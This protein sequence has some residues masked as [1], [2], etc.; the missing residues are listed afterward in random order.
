MSAF[1]PATDR[2]ARCARREKP[3][4]A[5]E[6]LRG[7]PGTEG[8]CAWKSYPLDPIHF[9]GG[10]KLTFRCANLAGHAV[11][12]VCVRNH[13]CGEFAGSADF[14]FR[15]EPAAIADFEGQMSAGDATVGFVVRLPMV[16]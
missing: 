13:G 6:G 3:S 11:L 10:T 15:V 9:G 8:S 14:S 2:T 7:E 1:S 5:P 16:R 12:D 4:R